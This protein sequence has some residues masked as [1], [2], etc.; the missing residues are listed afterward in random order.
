M[1]I[2]SALLLYSS[3]DRLHQFHEPDHGAPPA[4]KEGHPQSAGYRTLFLIFQFLTESTLMAVFSLLL[5]QV[6]PPSYCRSSTKWRADHD[7]RQPASSVRVL[8]LIIA[9]PVIVGLLAGS[10][11]AFFSPPSAPSKC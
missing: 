9:L 7:I 3:S 11:P 4:A 5:A 10:Y 6:T 2:F 1:Y 8:P